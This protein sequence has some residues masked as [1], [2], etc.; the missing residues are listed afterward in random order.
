MD[1]NTDW[2]SE[3]EEQEHVEDIQ[4]VQ[5]IQDIQD[6]PDID[7]KSDDLGFVLFCGYIFDKRT[8]PGFPSLD[9][10]LQEICSWLIKSNKLKVDADVCAPATVDFNDADAPRLVDVLNTYS[11]EFPLNFVLSENSENSGAYVA[12]RLR[13]SSPSTYSYHLASGV[14]DLPFFH[15]GKIKVEGDLSFDS[16]VDLLSIDVGRALT[17]DIDVSGSLVGCD[18]ESVRV[19]IDHLR[20]G[21]FE[22]PDEDLFGFSLC[23]ACEASCNAIDVDAVVVRKWEIS[24]TTDAKSSC[25]RVTKHF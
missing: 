6:I 13:L 22:N 8:R 3:D 18:S 24:F 12:R 17:S 11:P 19:A 9:K 1:P 5:D 10:Y 20:R 16:V 25:L 15:G 2:L 7:I 23:G 21:L 14:L 4:D